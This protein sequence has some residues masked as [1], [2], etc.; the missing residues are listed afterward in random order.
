MIYK[1]KNI[2]KFHNSNREKCI[3]IDVPEKT[4]TY[5]PV[6]HEKIINET[7]EN[8]YKN[9]LNVVSENYVLS[10]K[11]NQMIACFNIEADSTE[12]EMRLMAIN[13]YD[14]SI[15]V[16]YA[17]GLNVIVCSNGVVKGDLSAFKKKHRG[18][19]DTELSNNIIESVNLLSDR[20]YNIEKDVKRIKEVEI[21]FN[22]A[23]KLVGQMFIEEDLI[24]VEQASIIKKELEFSEHFKFDG[25]L[26]NFYNNCT[27]SFKHGTS[28]TY[29]KQHEKLHNFILN[30][31]E[32]V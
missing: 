19:V 15:S 23:S 16:G 2:L 17:T 1:S 13:S 6:S 28:K 27:Q 10:A 8:L 11:G 14:K 22:L 26:W 21:D 25:S 31:F 18:L 30:E 3:S 12:L 29:L 32:L 5:S 7:L 24:T 9:N 20:Y 4:Q